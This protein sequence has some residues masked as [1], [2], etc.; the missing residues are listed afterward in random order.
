ME[1]RGSGLKSLII[2]GG[3]LVVAYWY[4]NI[5]KS[6]K[7][8]P[9]DAIDGKTTF[10]SEKGDSFVRGYDMPTDI[11]QLK[12]DDKGEILITQKPDANIFGEVPSTGIKVTVDKENKTLVYKYSPTETW[13]TTYTPEDISKL[14]L[15]DKKYVNG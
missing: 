8:N 10:Y 6:K 13:I 4:F 11:S 12:P 7:V 15:I 1:R 2:I 3:I 5:R 9:Q 14:V